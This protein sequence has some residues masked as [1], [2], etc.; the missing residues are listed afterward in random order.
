MAGRRRRSRQPGQLTQARSAR[1]SGRSGCTWRP[2]ASCRTGR[3][4]SHDR[5]TGRCAGDRRTGPRPEIDVR[6]RARQQSQPRRI[7]PHLTHMP[8]S[9]SAHARAFGSFQ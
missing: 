5:V 4:T 3:D 7:A 2:T 9:V 6:S 1:T 8:M